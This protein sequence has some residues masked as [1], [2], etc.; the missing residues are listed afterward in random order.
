[1]LAT[2]IA[3]NTI[4]L[5]LDIVGAMLLFTHG[6]PPGVLSKKAG[7]VILWGIGDREQ[8]Q[9]KIDRHIWIGRSAI[10]LIVVGFM[11][12]LIAPVFPPC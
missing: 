9:R 7:T 3:F 4:G 12:Q 11:L 5:I 8:E 10:G 2:E 1:M 6:P